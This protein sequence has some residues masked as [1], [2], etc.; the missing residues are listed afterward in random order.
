MERRSMF[1]TTGKLTIAVFMVI[2]SISV[3]AL[4]SYPGSPDGDDTSAARSEQNV[5]VAP[6]TFS[7]APSRNVIL[8]TVTPLPS[9]TPTLLPPP[10][11]EPPT[12]TPVC[13][14]SRDRPPGIRSA[15]NHAPKDR[16]TTYRSPQAL[17]IG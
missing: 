10:T 7:R 15:E 14:R 3:G 1:R 13:R 12:T 9:E 17:S 2:G 5:Q 16:H 8:P 6:P 11:F 4:L